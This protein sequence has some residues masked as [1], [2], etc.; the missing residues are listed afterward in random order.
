M[1]ARMVWALKNEHAVLT[2]DEMA[3]ADALTI[4]GGMSGAQL[5]ENAG[6]AV[7][8]VVLAEFPG[9]R[10]AVVLCGPGNNGGD[11][12][13]AAR[14]LAALGIETVVFR[15]RPPKPGTDAEAAASGWH[16][17]GLPLSALRLKDGD[18]VIDALYGA[19]FSG[20]MAGDDAMAAQLARQA[21][22]SVISVDLPSGV[23]G[24]T[25]A[26][27]GH[28]FQ[29]AHTVTF[30]RKKPGHLL[31]SG[32]GNCGR[33][34]V[35]DIGIRGSVLDEIAPSLWENGPE[36]FAA[37][38]P[39]PDPGTHKY[40][41][42]HA[43]VF[44]GGSASTGAA[45]L[46]ATAAA[47]AG[48]GAVTVFAPGD[49]MPA[50]AA[51]LTSIMLKQADNAAE[52]STALGDPRL[53]ALV[54]GPGFGRYEWLRETVDL[55]LQSGVER[56]I[57]L[58]ADVFSAFAGKA[59]RLSKLIRSSRGR[60]VLTPHEGE[61]QRL[62]PD[63]FNATLGKHEK[64]REAAKRSGA[65]VLY[66]GADTV[67][68][69]PDGRAAMNTNGGPELAT[70][71]SGDVLAGIIAGLLAQGMPAFEAACAGA[72]MHGEAGRTAGKG[73]VAED[74]VNALAAHMVHSSRSTSA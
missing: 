44:S 13:V 4:Q 19:G 59:E 28:S 26:C 25:G 68:A 21:G 39:K 43:G 65:T 56:G 69:S 42:G 16:G 35:A 5:M 15:G 72:W 67:I 61:F 64:C 22:A 8:S 12:Y 74:I 41:R 38:L 1:E 57:V 40:K 45:R 62:F 20:D 53:S 11:G 55:V 54:I 3:R 24:L 10:R 73:A 33:L 23:S 46:A 70:A 6:H 7:K 2:P 14:L 9:I 52:L 63:I 18:V 17:P 58:D 50:L 37:L 36:M 34:H 49:A 47:R 51:Q 30:F 29:A 27:E 71:G 32:R 48:A 31:C 60:V 66:K